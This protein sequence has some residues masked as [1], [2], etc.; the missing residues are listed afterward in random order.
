MSYKHVIYL[1]EPFDS[2]FSLNEGHGVLVPKGGMELHDTGM[3][4]SAKTVLL[5]ET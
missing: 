4:G 1:N 2:L 5:K 3:V